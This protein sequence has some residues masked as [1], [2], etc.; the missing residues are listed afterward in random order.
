M[1]DL[2]KLQE[3]LA[4]LRAQG[5]AKGGARVTEA[6]VDINEWTPDPSKPNNK[7]KNVRL[8]LP[9]SMNMRPISIG[10]AAV[11]DLADK[12]LDALVDFAEKYKV[13][14][15]DRTAGQL[16]AIKANL[17]AMLDVAATIIGERLDGPAQQ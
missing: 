11:V 15:A 10:A 14:V 13:T 4:K 5:G 12:D 1:A 7:V 6:K 3:Q 9:S 8:T 16:R 17:Q 2:K